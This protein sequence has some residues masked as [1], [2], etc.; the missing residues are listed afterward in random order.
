MND[1]ILEVKNLE[2]SFDGEKVIDN[3]S[4]SL[5]K[6]ENLVVVGPNGAGKTVLLKTLLPLLAATKLP[7]RYSTEHSLRRH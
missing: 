2:V 1:N 7:R 4:F 3:L 5:K 6:S